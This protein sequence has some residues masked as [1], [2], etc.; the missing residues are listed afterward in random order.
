MRLFD[1]LPR[2]SKKV[3]K[4]ERAKIEMDKLYVF[5]TNLLRCGH[6]YRVR[7]VLPGSSER[8]MCRGTYSRD[9]NYC[10]FILM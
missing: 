5:I 10:L 4:E 6:N 8:N 7:R 3:I 9:E 2:G 1:D